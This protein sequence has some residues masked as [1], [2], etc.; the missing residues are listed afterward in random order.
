MAGIGVDI[1]S[2]RLVLQSH[3]DFKWTFQNLDS[4]GTPTNFPGGQLWFE[5]D[6]GG[7]HNAIQQVT[8]SRASGG[9]YK[10]GYGS[11]WSVPIDYYDVTN[12][13]NGM[14]V[15]IFDA[16][17]GISGIGTSNV[18]VRSVRLSPE[19]RFALTLNAGVNEVQ[20]ITFTDSITMGKFKLTYGL[21]RTGELDFGATT[22]TI[23]TALEGLAGI[24]TGN[25]SVTS[26]GGTGYIVEFVG[27][28]SNTDVS[29][30]GGIARGIG[31]GLRSGALGLLLIGNVNV[32]TITRGTAKMGEKLVNT[33]N[34]AI[35]QYFDQFENLLGVDIAFNVTDNKNVTFVATSRRSYIESELT[36]FSVD[37]TGNNLKTFFNGI[38]SFL[39]VFDTINVDFRWNH[40]FEVEFVN[41]LGKQPIAP[42]NVNQST[43]TGLDGDQLV[44]V[45]VVRPGKTRLTKWPFT[46]TGDTATIKVESEAVDLIGGGTR[47]QLVFLPTGESAGG[48]MVSRGTTVVQA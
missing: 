17:S 26:D 6:S 10:L 14:G 45:V 46:I 42:L 43:L 25:V 4:T 23:E 8:V 16:I 11:I 30:I 33:L 13:P 21:N 12:A 18:E 35:N 15:D 20:H 37:V 2:E 7:E 28:L 36:T 22:T 38:S 39:G 48:S 31:F 34:N 44:E 47:W 5:F 27:A 41:A 19:W 9:T 40:T 24:G 29:Q 1:Q 3:R 32:E